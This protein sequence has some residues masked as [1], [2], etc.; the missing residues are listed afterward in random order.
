[1][2]SRFSIT[3]HTRPT[4]QRV[5]RGGGLTLGCIAATLV[6]VSCAPDSPSPAEPTSPTAEFATSAVAP[7]SFYQVS[8]GLDP[9]HTCGVTT[10]QQAYCWGTGYLGEGPGHSDPHPIPVA[11]AGGHQFRMISAGFDFTCGL[12][13]DNRAFCWGSNGTG[14][15]GDGTQIDRTTPVAAAPS[16]RFRDIVAGFVTTCGLTTGDRVYCWGSSQGG[17]M[18]TGSSSETF[19]NPPTQIAGGRTYNQVTLGLDHGCALTYTKEIY[20][21]GN[22]QQGEL[23]DSSTA[24]RRNSPSR[25][26]GTRT[27]VQVSAGWN[28]TCAVTASHQVWCWGDG[29]TGAI[30]DGKFLNRW[31]PRRVASSVQFDRVTSGVGHTCAESSFNRA[32]CWGYNSH[33]A[34]GDGTTTLRTTPV[35]VSG[36][37]FFAQLSASNGYSCGVT[38]DHRGYCWGSNDKG[39]LGDGTT[40]D[41]W[42]PTTIAG[43]S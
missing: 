26:S 30:G 31:E 23:G 6:A 14:Q 8:A 33:G 29:S 17:I 42:T 41:R 24:K 16:L 32:Y 13:T 2:S 21:W 11:V 39:N 19:G 9:K 10:S 43:P 37:L 1:M 22:N 38:S 25:V 35:A 4:P 3:D 34:L 18:G 36:G 27:F 12:T 5:L 40:N 15:L 28:N 20:C 7:L